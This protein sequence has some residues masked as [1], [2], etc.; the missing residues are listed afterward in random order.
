MLEKEATILVVDDDLIDLKISQKMLAEQYNVDCVTSGEAAIEYLKFT[1]PDLILLD[2]HMPGKDG[3]EVNKIIKSDLHCEDT[4]VVFLT[5]DDDRETEIKCFK[6]G[7]YDYIKKP[8]VVDIMLQRINRIIELNRLQKKLGTEVARQTRKAEA[9]RKKVERLSLQVMTTLA[10]TIDA[11]D[12]YTNGHSVR[13]AE[14]AREIARRYG[15]SEKEQQEIYYMGLLHDIGKIGIPDD[16]INKTSWLNDEEYDIIKTHP[17][18]GADILKN[19]SEIPGIEVGARWHHEKYDGT[20]YPD[21]LRGKNIPEVARII[22]V[23]DA[24]DAMTS[25]RSYRQ[26]LAQD[27]VREEIEKGKGT[28]FDPKFADIMLD[29]IDEDI[30]YNMRGQ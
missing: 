21:G 11:K 9:R 16:I 10:R 27:I 13:V 1:V 5:G 19:I 4:A 24:Y 26:V 18:I 28:Q 12:K 29:M 25:S 30:E 7:A 23:A 15:K 6:E 20:G 2:I 3:F 14:Y 22:C 8:Y 17:V